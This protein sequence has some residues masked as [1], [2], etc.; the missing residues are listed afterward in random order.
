ML[1]PQLA[2]ALRETAEIYN[3]GA[4]LKVQ[5][6]ESPGLPAGRVEL[7]IDKAGFRFEDTGQGFVRVL[8]IGIGPT[9]EWARVEPVLDASGGAVG[10]REQTLHVQGRSR[11]RSLEALTEAYLLGVVRRRLL[12]RKN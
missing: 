12:N 5:V 10:W 3:Q 4:S 2:T 8:E 11:D 7:T 9:K 6:A 1:L